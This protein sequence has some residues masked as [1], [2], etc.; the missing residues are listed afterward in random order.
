MRRYL[1]AMSAALRHDVY[2]IYDADMFY[3]RWLID[4]SRRRHAYGLLRDA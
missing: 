3:T 2:A 1:M 4:A